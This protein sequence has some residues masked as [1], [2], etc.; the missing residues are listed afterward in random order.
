MAVI[1]VFPVCFRSASSMLLSPHPQTY[2]PL[3]MSAGGLSLT[4]TPL[5][6]NESLTTSRRTF[7]H[8]RS[9]ESAVSRANLVVVGAGLGSCPNNLQDPYGVLKSLPL[10][11]VLPTCILPP[12][13][14][15]PLFLLLLPLPASA[16]TI[17]PAS[18]PPALLGPLQWGC[19]ELRYVMGGAGGGTA[20]EGDRGH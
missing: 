5:P 3:S 2:P 12:V 7:A 1:P 18:L 13:A 4:V 15:A 16:T 11:L 19:L 6:K 8:Y 17:P 20:R 10:L 14:S 9:A